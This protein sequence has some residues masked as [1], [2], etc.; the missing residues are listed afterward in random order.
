M[1]TSRRCGVFLGARRVGT[2]EG[3][4]QLS[5]FSFD[6][7]YKNDAR[8]PVLGLGF[9]ENLDRVHREHGALPAWF[10]N[11][12]PE[13]RLRSWIAEKGGCGEEDDL[14][15]LST[16]GHDLPGNVIVVDDEGPPSELSDLDIEALGS[17]EEAGAARWRFSLAG[18]AFKLSMLKKDDKFT[19]PGSGEYGDWI[20]KLPDRSYPQVPR[21]EFAM[22]TLAG[23]AGISVPEVRL[24]HRDHF[25]DVPEAFW[26]EHEDYAYAVR[27]F[28]RVSGGRVHIEDLAQVRF[29]PPA[30][31]YFGTFESVASILYRRADTLSLQEFARRLAFNIVIQNGD[32]HLKNWSF[33]YEDGARPTVSP[34]YDLVS[35]AVYCPGSQKEDLGLR[36]AKS[37]DFGRI[38]VSDFGRLERKLRAEAAQLE[39]V[40]AVAVSAL[41]N[42]WSESESLLEHFPSLRSH[43]NEE[44]DARARHLLRR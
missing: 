40:V 7:D 29:V 17:S 22:M 10:A 8:R 9:E 38:K 6:D 42:A 44:L 28:D 1:K 27:R 12:L 14:Q 13:G 31:K 21:N 19:A 16:V 43:L 5:R 36:F 25:S 35:T 30:D 15:L 2:L 23:L 34:A 3:H 32:A 41:R 18:V 24:V 33:V 26:P 39:D 37:K 4:G 11:L 20:I